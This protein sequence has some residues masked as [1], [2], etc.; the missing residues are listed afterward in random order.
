MFQFKVKWYDDEEN[1]TCG[2]VVGKTYEEAMSHLVS[3][4]GESNTTEVAL[5][6]LDCLEGVLCYRSGIEDLTSSFE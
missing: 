2:L 4:F 3:Y 5:V 6:C 1:E